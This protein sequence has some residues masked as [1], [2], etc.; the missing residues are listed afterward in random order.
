[1]AEPVTGGDQLGPDATIQTFTGRLSNM[2]VHLTRQGRMWATVDLT[3]PT[4]LRVPVDVYPA[5][6]PGPLTEPDGSTVTVTGRV[7][8]R[9]P[10]PRLLLIPPADLARA[11]QE[12]DLVEA[13][14]NLRVKLWFCPVPGHSNRRGPT[15]QRVLT[16]EW[17]GDVAHC[18]APGCG[19]TSTNGQGCNCDEYNCDGS[20]CGPGNCTCTTGK[21][22]S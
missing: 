14:G 22:T 16:V 2:Q 19:R 6:Y 5:A 15:G 17:D 10:T 1:M 20:C 21:E 9:G 8:R 18:T 4:G 7:D 12:D 3:T 13:F 11:Q